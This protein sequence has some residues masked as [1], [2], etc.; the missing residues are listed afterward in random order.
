MPAST[1]R[2][3]HRRQVRLADE[4]DDDYWFPWDPIWELVLNDHDDDEEENKINQRK[5]NI[6]NHK[7][8]RLCKTSHFTKSQNIETNITQQAYAAAV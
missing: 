3:G 7:N 4:V 1:N 5:Q 2:Q 8:G 6:I